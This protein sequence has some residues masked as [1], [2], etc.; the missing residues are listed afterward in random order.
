[1]DAWTSVEKGSQ[2]DEFL[3]NG[4]NVLSEKAVADERD[5]A[6]RS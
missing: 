2:H 6:V 3:M 5:H 4:G 1:M